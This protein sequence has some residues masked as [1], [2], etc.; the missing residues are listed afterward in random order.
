M[1]QEAV[2][3][4]EAWDLGYPATCTNPARWKAEK[5][6]AVPFVLCGRHLHRARRAHYSVFKIGAAP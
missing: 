3:R 1:S 4:C 2:R 6:Q 5:H